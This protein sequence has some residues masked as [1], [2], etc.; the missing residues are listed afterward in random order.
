MSPLPGSAPEYQTHLMLFA[1]E[2]ARP[3]YTW[4]S[5]IDAV[6]PLYAELSSR[7]R[8]GGSLEY[9]GLSFA[10]EHDTT[11][12]TQDDAFQPWDP[13]RDG[14]SRMPPNQAA[15]DEKFRLYAYRNPGLF[16][17][18]PELLSLRTL[19]SGQVMRTTLDTLFQKP[20][21]RLTS[22]SHLYVCT[23]G[24][25]DCRCGVVGTEVYDALKDKV[26]EHESRCKQQ[27]SQP[28]RRIRV[29]EVSHVGGHKWAANVL[30]YPHGDWYG[31]VRVS[32]A[33]LL[34]R[35]ALAPASSRHDLEDLRERLV[36]WPRW[37]GRLGMKAQQA[38]DHM[39]LWGPPVVHT[40]QI[41]PRARG[42]SASE[43]SQA[44]STQE[45]TQEYPGAKDSAETSEH[46]T[47]RFH[48][49]DGT[50]YD[51]QGQEGETLMDT[52][53][54]HNL[55]SIEA[56]CG[57]ELECA[58][59]HAYLCNA[60][61]DPNA[62]GDITQ[63]VPNSDELFGSISD[64]EDDMLEYAIDRQPTSR[65]TCQIPVTRRIAQWMQNG[66]RVELPRY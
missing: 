47:L 65:L 36:L 60:A 23:H 5:H 63:E 2:H 26:Q 44:A 27:N 49:Y 40:A 24:A 66:G 10:S 6:C 21:A 28:A 17:E 20:S 3:D 55:P 19:P 52:A 25:R 62:R 37:R 54:R 50:W 7:T 48:G 61:A 14:S 18:Y 38:R 45:N 30:A 42:F 8:Q 53:T 1:A 4:P 58:T 35:A 43:T 12:L 31:N 46:H 59:C 22:E 32:D 33:P 16:V 41:A 64:E 15:E 39:D 29:M 51:V 9:Y 57:G 11:Q 34:V 13:K 56:T